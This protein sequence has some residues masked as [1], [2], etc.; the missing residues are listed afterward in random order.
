[1]SAK[2]TQP[3]LQEIARAGQA[4]ACL[5]CRARIIGLAL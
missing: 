4:A 1:M 3:S 5:I 2:K